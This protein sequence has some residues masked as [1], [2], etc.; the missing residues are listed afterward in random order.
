VPRILLL[1]PSFTYRAPDFVAAAA[2]L[3]A[4][5]VVG[6]DREQALAAA[7]GDRAVVVDLAAV[8][9]GVA[10]IVDLHNRSPVDAVVAI[11]DQGVIVAAEAAAQL[12]F[13]HNPPDATRRTRDKLG[14]RR[15]L[16][17]GGVR[18]PRYL[19]NE[20]PSYPCVVKPL[21][22][23]ASRG[24]IKVATAAEFD[25]TVARVRAICG[26]PDAPVLVE[27]YIDGVELAVEGLLDGGDLT[28]LAVF[29]KP[30]PLDGPYFEE[31]IYVTPSRVDTA[32]AVDLVRDGCRAMGLGEGPI[33]AEVRI[34][35]DGTPWLIEIASRSIGGLCARSLRFGAGISL[36]EVILR[37]ALGLP[38]GDVQR[39]AAASGVMMIPIRERGTLERVD[40]LEKAREVDGIVGVEIT[41]PRGRHVEPLP[42]GDRYLGFIFARGGTPA[43]VEAALRDAHACLGVVLT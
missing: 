35:G 5:V 7:M 20:A 40:G 43:D 23:S 9:R 8:D 17:A 16:D 29:D 34:D 38:V 1:V 37:H 19:L 42:E 13:R 21:A 11:D 2:A 10:A 12:G 33:H 25:A 27:E 32:A 4:E 41:V 39:E 22:L 3:G 28:V 24:V 26:E 30:D 14:M 18:Q 31:T 6:S 36:E 15:A